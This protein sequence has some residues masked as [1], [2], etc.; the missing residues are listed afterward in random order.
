[1][2]QEIPYY[3]IKRVQ[4]H[5]QSVIRDIDMTSSWKMAFWKGQYGILQSGQL[6]EDVQQMSTVVGVMHVMFAL[7][8]AWLSLICNVCSW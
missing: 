7:S 3:G 2:T 5:Q 4:V 1:M 8:V 6:I